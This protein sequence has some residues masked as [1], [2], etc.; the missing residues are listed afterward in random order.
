MKAFQICAG[1][2]PPVTPSEVI[3][4]VT[5]HGFVLPVQDAFISIWPSG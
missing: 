4:L 1:K 2:D 3:V 5:R